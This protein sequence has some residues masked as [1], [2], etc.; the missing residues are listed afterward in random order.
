M[1]YL[2]LRC[3]VLSFMTGISCQLFYETVVPRRRWRQQWMEHSV[4]PAFTAVFLL[5]SVAWLPPYILRPVRIILLTA[6]I[7]QIYFQIHLIKNLIVSVTFCG[8]YWS[9]STAVWSVLSLYMDLTLETSRQFF[10]NLSEVL[11]LGLIMIFHYRCRRRFHKFSEARWKKTGVISFLYLITIIALSML[12]LNPSATDGY[13]RLTAVSGFAILS[14]LLFYFTMRILEK[15]D[16]LQKLRLSTE[17]AQRQMAVYQTMQKHYE[18]QRSFLHD[19]KNQ[20]NCIQ[21]LL[22]CGQISEASDYITRITGTLR[23]QF[24]DINTNHT[25]V[26]ILLNQKYQTACEKAVTM[27]F[28]INDLSKL[29][30]PEEDLV[31]LLA[32]LLDNAIE[33]CEK[34]DTIQ[35]KMVL[36]EGQLILSVRN[37]VN[38]P[39]QIK[40]NMIVTSKKDSLH[41]G[42][43]LSNVDAVI[44][45]YGGTSVLACDN[46]C[47]SFSALLYNPLWQ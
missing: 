46:G 14:I 39:V 30:M 3:L 40:N 27:T 37:P 38:T 12:T 10:E 43:G 26:N 16:A 1:N 4:L 44:K 28:A 18:Q 29:T 32:N 35:F 47:F 20:L 5:I 8:I 45:K 22:L 6:L 33:A 2:L 34:L 15:E 11:L 9:I 23:E 21:G 19:Y 17:H 42:I 25:I 41:H 36:E 7:A 31:T 24:G 13:A